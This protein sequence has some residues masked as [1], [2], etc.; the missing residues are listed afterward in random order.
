MNDASGAV[1]LL[2]RYSKFKDFIC[3][4]L[5]PPQ[6]I[7]MMMCNRN[8]RVST[9]RNEFLKS[10][11]GVIRKL[12][13]HNFRELIKRLPL[14]QTVLRKICF[15]SSRGSTSRYITINSENLKKKH[16]QDIKPST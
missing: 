12:R 5:F 2:P 15:Q 6:T 4:C 11:S 9:R 3:L 13:S 16:N 14:S 10:V 7:N 1:E 8:F